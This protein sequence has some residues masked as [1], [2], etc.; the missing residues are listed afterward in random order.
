MDNQKSSTKQILAILLLVI[1]L[2]SVV[3]GILALVGGASGKDPYGARESVVLVASAVTL[4]NGQSAAGTGTGF[5]IGKPGKKVEYIVTNAHVVE[6]GYMSHLSEYQSV[7]AYSSIQV[8]FS[9]AENDFVIPEV[10]YY[11]PKDQK[12][13]AILKLPSA[14]DKRKAITIRSSESVDPGDEVAS[15]GYPGI[16]SDFSSYMTYD[17]DDITVTKGTVTRKTKPTGVT[18]SAL[19]TDDI[20]NHGNSGG[21]LV[22]S[23]G[24]LVGICSASIE[25]VQT[26]IQLGVCYAIESDEL[27]K[28]LD[29]EKIVYAKSGGGLSWLPT[30]TAYIFLPVGGVCLAAGIVLFVLNGKSSAKGEDSRAAV[31]RGVYNA[32]DKKAVLRGVTGKYSGQSFDLTKAKLILGRDPAFCNLVYDKDTP[33]ISARHCQVAYDSAEGCFIITDLGSSYGTFLG[34]GKKLAPNVPEKLS[35]GDTFYLCDNT[36]RFL[37]GK[38]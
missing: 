26:G 25:N 8:Y 7:V 2:V 12:D 17:Q 18:Y 38:E 14:T 3:F 15:V 11:S 23:K 33:G 30:W 37:V 9:A 10:V 16:T 29:S 28:I 31:A 20:I 32:L 13:I 4:V 34:N 35:I 24:N 5:A 6:Y 21:P 36:N 1:G 19:Q 27:L 22:D